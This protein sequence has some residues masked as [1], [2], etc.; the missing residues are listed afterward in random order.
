VGAEGLRD[1][2]EPPAQWL[3]RMQMAGEGRVDCGDLFG[4]ALEQ[5]LSITRR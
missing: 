5:T 3:S 4:D 2:F 1:L